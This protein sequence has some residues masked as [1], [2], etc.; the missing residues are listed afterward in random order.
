MTK[1]LG[2]TFPLAPA[3]DVTVQIGPFEM[4]ANDAILT[5]DCA[6]D[7]ALLFLKEE[8]GGRWFHV[9]SVSYPQGDTFG[10]LKTRA[11][12]I[13]SPNTKDLVVEHLIGDHGTGYLEEYFVILRVVGGQLRAVLQTIEHYFRSGFPGVNDVDEQ[14]TFTFDAPTAKE[15]GAVAERLVIKTDKFPQIVLERG[16]SWDN[17]SN[18]YAPDGWDTIKIPSQPQ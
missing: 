7:F 2:L 1:P 3:C 6:G 18:M 13:Y 4:N 14:S 16:F 10:D 11:L 17:A 5:V 9:N 8:Q 15:P 12:N